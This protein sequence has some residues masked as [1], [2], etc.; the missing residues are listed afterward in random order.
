[1]LSAA[2]ALLMLVHLAN[3]AGVNTGR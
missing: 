2:G 3:L 1:V